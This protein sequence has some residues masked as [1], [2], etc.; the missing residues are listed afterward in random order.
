MSTYGNQS[1]TVNGPACSYV[2]LAGYNGVPPSNDKG[3]MGAPHVPA[4]T[5]SGLYVVPDYGT[6][7]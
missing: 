2:S 5:V 7:G 1:N 6:I 4:T 3:G